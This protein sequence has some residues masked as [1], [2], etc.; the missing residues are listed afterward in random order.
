MGLFLFIHVQLP[1]QRLSLLVIE[2]LLGIALV[3]SLN[4][5]NLYKL[6]ESGHSPILNSTNSVWFATCYH[7]LHISFSF[8]RWEG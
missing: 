2:I 4:C 5:L 7:Y 1:L 8:E 6:Q 3:G